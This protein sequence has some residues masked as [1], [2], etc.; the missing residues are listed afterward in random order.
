MIIGIQI[1]GILFSLF[2]IYYT[3]I[4]YKKNEFTVKE[5][6]FW[7]VIWTL[8]LFLTLVPQILDP[9]I[10]TLRIARTLDL[11]VILGFMF[12]IGC[13]IY[14]YGLVRINQKRLDGIVRKVA[15]DIEKKEQKK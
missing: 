6:V 2:M 13:V 10:S 14:T 12:L 8:F 3:F 1:I 11:F 7:F 5:S 15:F 9:V 4:H